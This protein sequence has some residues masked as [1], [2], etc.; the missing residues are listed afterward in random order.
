ME[1]AFLACLIFPMPLDASGGVFPIISAFSAQTV[2]STTGLADMRYLLSDIH[3]Q[4]C[5][6]MV[7]LWQLM[8]GNNV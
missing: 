8:N 5:K 4:S 3:Y 6:L 7:R 1:H 2:A